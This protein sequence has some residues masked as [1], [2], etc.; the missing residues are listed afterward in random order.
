[1]RFD[2]VDGMVYTRENFCIDDI[3]MMPL[4]GIR[5]PDF[6]AIDETTNARLFTRHEELSEYIERHLHFYNTCINPRVW[7]YINNHDPKKVFRL[8][9][10]ATPMAMINVS[11]YASSE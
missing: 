9:G 5:H 10:E 11:L 1:M 7:R 6:P 8:D 3:P 4:N 2:P